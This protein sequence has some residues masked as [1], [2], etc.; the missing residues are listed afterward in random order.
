MQHWFWEEEVGIHG[1]GGGGGRYIHCSK[2]GY[3]IEVSQHFCPSL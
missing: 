3:F 2:R 1:G